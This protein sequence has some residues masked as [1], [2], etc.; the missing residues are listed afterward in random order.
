LFR[1]W[2][3]YF[4]KISVS[5]NGHN[6]VKS[7]ENVFLKELLLALESA[8]TRLAIAVAAETKST[9]PQQR[10][11][12]LETAD[13]MRRCLRKLRKW[14]GDK[15]PGRGDWRQALEALKHLPRQGKALKLSQIL[16]KVVSEIDPPDSGS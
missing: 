6:P 7:N 8:R 13:Q 2:A 14:N 11:H 9:P 5:L 16:R 15:P 3:L 12:Y 1:V 10:Q 4:R